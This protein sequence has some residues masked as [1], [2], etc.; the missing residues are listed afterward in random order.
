MDTN[1]E[2]Y[3]FLKKGK[4]LKSRVSFKSSKAI[5]GLISTNVI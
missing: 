5:M 2:R 4:Y 1:E 3:Q